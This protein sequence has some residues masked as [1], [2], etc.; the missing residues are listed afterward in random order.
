VHTQFGWHVI[1]L[2]SAKVTPFEQ[3]KS[4]L[5]AQQGGGA[6]VQWL[7]GRLSSAKVEVNPRYGRFDRS[8]GNVVPITSTAT[9][10]P[11]SPTP[12]SSTPGASTP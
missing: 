12:S 3:V 7:K 10:Q 5:V 2:I 4:Q 6:F 1:E 8:T 9:G 11:S